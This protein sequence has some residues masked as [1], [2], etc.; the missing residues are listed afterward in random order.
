MFR[1]TP[2]GD[3]RDRYIRADPGVGLLLNRARLFDGREWLEDAS[4]T[5]SDGVI[6]QIG[7]RGSVTPPKG[8]RTVDLEGLS[9]LPGL[10]DCWCSVVGDPRGPDGPDEPQ[11]QRFRR[12]GPILA[13]RAVRDA[14]EMLSGGITA[15]AQLGS[16]E[17][18]YVVGLGEAIRSGLLAGPTIRSAG[19]ALSPTG[20]GVAG[21]AGPVGHPRRPLPGT[22]EFRHPPPADAD[23]LD[24]PDAYR[25]R[26]REQFV[27]GADLAMLLL[28]SPL[29]SERV[30]LTAAEL[31]AAVDEPQ[32][33]GAKIACLAVGLAP[34]KAAVRAGV[35]LLVCGPARPDDELVELLARGGTAWAPSLVG[36]HDGAGMAL[37]VAVRRVHDAGGRIVVAS[38]W[39]PGRT[40]TFADELAALRA[41]GLSVE[42]VLEAA[43][44]N[45]AR[46]LGLATGRLRPGEPAD[47]VAF[48]AD[49]RDGLGRIARPHAAALI[50][51]AP[52]RPPRTPL[53]RIL[54]GAKGDRP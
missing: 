44:A 24:T 51:H 14:H 27:G 4:V 3:L 49:R 28:T 30:P 45:G 12:S 38:G 43:T 39:C 11:A 50:V 53:Q 5:V 37:A 17:P 36:R 18:E 22:G 48:A 1:Y 25:K 46:A 26:I 31:A 20:G 32:R 35:D 52:P 47:L 23:V 10:V 6:A 41:A 7:A 42:A 33:V 8:A 40:A 54:A 13:H 15:V 16:A 21:R 2:Q 19:R 9:L 34:A 29:P